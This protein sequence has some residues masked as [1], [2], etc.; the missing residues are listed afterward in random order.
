MKTIRSALAAIT[1]ATASFAIAAPALAQADEYP[2][3]PGDYV[4]VSMIKIKDG[5]DLDY[6]NHLAGLWRK[7]QDYS[8]AQGWITDYQIWT[9]SNAREGEAD[10]FLITWFPRIESA[11]EGQARGKK[12]R[13]HMQQT[14]A[15]A[16]AQSGKRAEYRTLAGSMLLRNQV[17]R[18][19]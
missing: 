1:L 16:Q 2:T 10:V 17:W 9:N 18:K 12:F 11:E 14:I 3:V 19:K 8:K 5:H 15:Q 7:G 13:E 6:A 4:E